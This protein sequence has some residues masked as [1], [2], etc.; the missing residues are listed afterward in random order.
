MILPR[1]ARRDRDDYRCQEFVEAVT[2][3]LEGAMPAADR[4]RF[5]RHLARCDGCDT[6]LEQ[7]RRTVE[8]TGRLTV[9]DV[10]ELGVEARDRLVDAFREFHDAS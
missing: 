3:Y 10:Y 6:Y 2:D 8:L 5:D 9:G 1:L 4:A 7:I